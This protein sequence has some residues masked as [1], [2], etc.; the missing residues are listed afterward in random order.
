MLE[1]ARCLVVGHKWARH[2]YEA[3][4]GDDQPEGIFL[5][6]VRCGK[7]MK[8]TDCRPSPRVVR[9]WVGDIA[10]RRRA[11]MAPPM[12]SVRSAE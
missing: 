10:I 11:P 3:T 6:C 9:G 1:A 7:V 8:A 12:A 5:K 4:Q 2:R